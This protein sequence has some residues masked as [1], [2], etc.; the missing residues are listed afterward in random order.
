MASTMAVRLTAWVL[1]LGGLVL[2][3]APG[4]IAVALGTPGPMPANGAS[5]P[6][7]MTFWRQLTFIRMFG[8]AAIGMGAICFWCRRSLTTPQQSSFLKVLVPVLALMV[9]MATAQQT[10][11][12]GTNAG[13]WIVAILAIVAVMCGGALAMTARRQAV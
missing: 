3:A 10:A 12:W 11:I 5:D 8:A 2:L 13:R 9:W 4:E 1:V 6:V 7:A